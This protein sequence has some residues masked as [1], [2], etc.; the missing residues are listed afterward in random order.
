M[1]KAKTHNKHTM[2]SELLYFQE[3]S[4]TTVPCSH[5]LILQSTSTLLTLLIVWG[6]RLASAQRNS[7]MHTLFGL[8]TWLATVCTLL[9][10]GLHTVAHWLHCCTLFGLGT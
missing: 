4:L 10:T 5:R 7:T 8:G 2:Q 3:Q 1:I 9:H 6:A